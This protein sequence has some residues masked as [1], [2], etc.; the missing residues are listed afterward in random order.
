L[1]TLA[2]G[3]ATRA[4]DL[5]VATAP[6]NMWE[7]AVTRT[8]AVFS[9]RT[10]GPLAEHDRKGLADTYERVPAEPGMTVFTTRLGLTMLDVIGHAEHPAA[11]RIA[12]NLHRRTTATTD[13]YAAGTATRSR[14]SGSTPTAS[15]PPPRSPDYRGG[16][17]TRATK[18]ERLSEDTPLPNTHQP[19]RD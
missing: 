9:D 1:A 16:S 10:L 4:A 8:L 17:V 18:A 15:T 3:D 5:L 7:Q 14:P 19:V 13:G 12:G 11:S 6:G 2:F